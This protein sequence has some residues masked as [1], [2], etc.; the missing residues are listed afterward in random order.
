MPAWGQR[1][2]VVLPKVRD[3]MNANAW[4]VSEVVLVFLVVIAINSIAGD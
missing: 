2:G 4:V 3:W 1:A